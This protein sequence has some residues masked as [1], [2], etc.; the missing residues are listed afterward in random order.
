M[1]LEFCKR[2]LF[3]SKN[4]VA[5]LMQRM[6]LAVVSYRKQSRIGRKPKGSGVMDN[7]VKRAFEAKTKNTLWIGDI[8]YLPLQ[9]GFLYPPT[10][11]T[12]FPI[13]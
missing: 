10:N 1:A 7:L 6:G 5:R 9:H 2:R 13:S 11:P 3:T 12:F 4:R 8:T